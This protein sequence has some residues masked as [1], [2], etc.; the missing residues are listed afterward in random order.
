MPSL[1]PSALHR[2]SS[3]D[4]DSSVTRIL[5]A[6][7][8]RKGRQQR[9][10]RGGAGRGELAAAGRGERVGEAGDVRPSR[11][12]RRCRAGG[13]LCAGGG[14]EQSRHGGA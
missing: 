5:C 4:S 10:G 1:V 7:G 8:A 14:R 2:I 11:Q 6:A 12:Q 13:G 3:A 9:G